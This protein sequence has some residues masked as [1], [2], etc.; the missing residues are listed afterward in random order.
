MASAI[1]R[2]VELCVGLARGW[3]G[4]EEE[5][6]VRGALKISISPW[7]GLYISRFKTFAPETDSA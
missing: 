4:C 3:P 1:F 5:H 2:M 7:K 6:C